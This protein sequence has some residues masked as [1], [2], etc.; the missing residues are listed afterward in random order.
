M[1]TMVGGNKENAKAFQHMVGQARNHLHEVSGMAAFSK[2][3]IK[4]IHENISPFDGFIISNFTG[5][6]ITESWT[7]RE[8]FVNIGNR[9]RLFGDT[10]RQMAS[11]SGLTKQKRTHKMM[12]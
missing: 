11:I 4:T 10:K 1:S 12:K 7:D 2:K 5:Q 8:R 9:Y 3:S 6:D